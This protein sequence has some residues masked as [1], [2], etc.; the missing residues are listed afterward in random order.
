MAKHVGCLPD[1][2]VRRLPKYLVRAR[3]LRVAGR[4]WVSSQ[5]LAEDLGLTSSTVRQD[6]SH[7]DLA[8]VSKRGYETLRLEA[9]LS[10]TLG[11]DVT[12]RL[13]IVGAGYLGCALALHGGLRAQGFETC[14]VFDSDREVVGTE[15]GDLR[16][17]PMGALNGLVKRKKVEIGMIAVPAASAQ[18]V[19]DKL[20]E[21]GVRGL[22]N[23]AYCHVRVPEHVEVV[24]ARIIASLQ[25]LAYVIRAKAGTGTP[26]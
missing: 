26:S 12:L 16:V 5:G 20:V 13:V 6:L 3:E 8:G 10:H 21:A 4:E 14:G 11:A 23:L 7:L 18:E 19:A 25:Q 9:A 2:V 24:D 22:L 17:R 15:V 1:P